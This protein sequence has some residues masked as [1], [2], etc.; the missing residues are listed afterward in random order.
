[1]N[2]SVAPNG[3]LLVA[4]FESCYATSDLGSKGDGG[5]YDEWDGP[6]QPSYDV[7]LEKVCISGR[8]PEAAFEGQLR[9]QL[10]C[11]LLVNCA[12]AAP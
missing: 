2:H 10:P 5:G 9:V 6:R 4:I 12:T 8:A 3:G 7:T 1:M 11:S